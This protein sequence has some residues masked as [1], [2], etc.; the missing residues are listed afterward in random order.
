M[1]ADKKKQLAKTR[2]QDLLSLIKVPRKPANTQRPGTKAADLSNHR[3]K[4]VKTKNFQKASVEDN[5]GVEQNEYPEP[6]RPIQKASA[7]KASMTSDKVLKAGVSLLASIREAGGLLKWMEVNGLEDNADAQELEE[8]CSSI[9]ELLTST[10]GAQANEQGAGTIEIVDDLCVLRGPFSMTILSR[11]DPILKATKSLA[12]KTVGIA[13][14]E[15]EEYP[16]VYALSGWTDCLKPNNKVLDSNFWT[17]H[18]LR[19][20]DLLQ[21]PFPSD[22]RDA[23][24][25]VPVGTGFACHVEN[26]LILFVACKLVAMTLGETGSVKKQLARM[27]ELRGRR[28][29][30]VEII[31]SKAPCVSCKN[32]R[33]VMERYTGIRF[34]FKVCLN[35]GELTPIK[36]ESRVDVYPTNAQE[37]FTPCSFEISIEK[38]AEM[39]LAST[40]VL[41]QT[42]AR[43]RPQA[44]V[45]T[46]TT[47]TRV[48]THQKFSSRMNTPSKRR[49]DE[50]DWDMVEW[51]PPRRKSKHTHHEMTPTRKRKSPRT[52]V[53]SPVDSTD[54]VTFDTLEQEVR[55]ME[56]EE[57]RHGSIFARRLFRC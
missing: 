29:P 18:A 36:N 3:N 24:H 8:L 47:I 32:F 17:Q 5:P 27:S 14:F 12:S 28:T 38:P 31:L 35:L 51:E 52:E 34:V 42:S 46:E 55:D 45:T 37:T 48:K 11:T 40:P 23:T 49:S 9:P 39:A 21:H 53:S 4:P 22:G 25:G 56:R 13:R 54:D 57:R 44:E 2:G 1:K 26:K 50:E 30:K 41:R 6:P 43:K 19:L 15:G 10:S 20:G 33:S 7:V 16:L